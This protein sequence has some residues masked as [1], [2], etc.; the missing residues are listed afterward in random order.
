MDRRKVTVCDRA[1]GH[2]DQGRGRGWRGEEASGFQV[3]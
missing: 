2:G 3:H 1:G